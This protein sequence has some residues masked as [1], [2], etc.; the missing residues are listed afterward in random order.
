MTITDCHTTNFTILMI[1]NQPQTYSRNMSE[2]K[3]FLEYNLIL[4]DIFGLLF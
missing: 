4:I 3:S 1:A 2:I